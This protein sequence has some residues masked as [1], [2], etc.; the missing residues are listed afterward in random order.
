VGGVY[1]DRVAGAAAAAELVQVGSLVHDDLLDSALVRRGT[2]T[3]NAVEGDTT[4]LLAGDF[5]LAQGG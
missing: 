1:D 5:M 4:V 2:P 3:V